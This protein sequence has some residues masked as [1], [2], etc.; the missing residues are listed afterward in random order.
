MA[1]AKIGVLGTGDVGQ[2]LGAA[3]LELGHE[4]KLG[5]RDAK[6]EK[7]DAWVKKHGGGGKASAGTFADAA[8]FGELLVLATLWSGTENA[9]KIAG[10]ENTAGKVVIDC[11]N[12]IAFPKQGQ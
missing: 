1:K 2:V 5:S 4:V 8:K 10:A 3:F 12:P 7:A 9:L 11:T 6:N